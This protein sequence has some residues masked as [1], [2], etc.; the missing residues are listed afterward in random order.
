MKKILFYSD[1]EDFGGHEIMSV[2]IANY[3][4]TLK[5]YEVE[6]FGEEKKDGSILYGALEKASGG[7]LLIDEVTEIPLET[8]SKILRV[9]IYLMVLL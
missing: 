3:L 7:V 6:L 1:T 2:K 4:S 8:Q 5:K 9:V